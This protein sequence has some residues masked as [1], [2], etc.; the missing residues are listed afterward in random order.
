M[1]EI[2]DV[3][4]TAYTGD[5]FDELDLIK[6]KEDPE[7]RLLKNLIYAELERRKVNE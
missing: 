6:H 1:Q 3:I 5:L 7:S 2:I 4:Q